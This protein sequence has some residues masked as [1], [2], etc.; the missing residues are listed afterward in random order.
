MP[1]TNRTWQLFLNQKYDEFGRSELVTL[2]DLQAC[3]FYSCMEVGDI[4]G[5]GVVGAR[6]PWSDTPS[7]IAS[8]KLLIFC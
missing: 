8:I 1:S 5:E 3:T 4:N 6:P 7:N 2:K